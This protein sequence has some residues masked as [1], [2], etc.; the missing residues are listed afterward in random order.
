[1]PYAQRANELNPEFPDAIN[2]LADTLARLGRA[3]K[4]S[5]LERAQRSHPRQ[6]PIENTWGLALVALGRREAAVAHFKRS[7]ELQPNLAAAHCIL[8]CAWPNKV[9]SP[10]PSRVSPAPQ[11][12]SRITPMPR[13]T[14]DLRSR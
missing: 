5:R 11:S 7:I 6:A 12:C 13:F 4:A 14:G 2:T 10:Q 9:T 3:A 8:V 1:L